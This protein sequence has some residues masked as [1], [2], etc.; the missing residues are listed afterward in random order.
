M[1]EITKLKNRYTGEIVFCRDI[2]KVIQDNSY[3]F[4]QVYKKE[5]PGRIY[6]VNLD[7]YII[8]TK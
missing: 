7:A 3:T 4:V 8:L 1:K 5:L 6:L 2:K